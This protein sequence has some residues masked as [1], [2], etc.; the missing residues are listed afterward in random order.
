MG[1]GGAFSWGFRCTKNRGGAVFVAASDQ[2]S[3]SNSNN[4]ESD[5]LNAVDSGVEYSAFAALDSA[6]NDIELDSPNV[7]DSGVEYSAFAALDSIH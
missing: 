4:I 5:S 6:S 3:W 7:V 1:R 2:L